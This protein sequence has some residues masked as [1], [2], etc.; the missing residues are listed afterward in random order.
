M[1]GYDAEYMSRWDEVRVREA[2]RNGRVVLTRR[3]NIRAC[4]S[5][6]VILHDRL[7]DQIRQIGALYDLKQNAA[8]FSRCNTCNSILA[9]VSREEV[10]GLVPEYVQAT[11]EFFAR[12]PTCGR[13]YW[14]GTHFDN[15]RVLMDSLMETGCRT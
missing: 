15:A 7:S 9:E 8:P 14:K 5:M 12:C 6:I 3:Q 4:S 2:I 11:Q 13:I 10:K 1:F